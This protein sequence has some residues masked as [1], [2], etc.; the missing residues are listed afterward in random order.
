MEAERKAHPVLTRWLE[1]IELAKKLAANSAPAG[2]DEQT[3][4]VFS[5][6]NTTEA[7]ADT[8]YTP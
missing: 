6:A 3:S 4:E 2:D 5:S 7:M 8:V 1:E